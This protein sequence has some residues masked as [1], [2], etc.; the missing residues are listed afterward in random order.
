MEAANIF[1]NTQ[2]RSR[3][4]FVARAVRET[5][6]AADVGRDAAVVGGRFRVLQQV[7]R[8]VVPLCVEVQLAVV[9]VVQVQLGLD[10]ELECPSCSC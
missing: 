7:E 6:D 9:F 4:E 8:V 3:L 5:D 1:S 2:G 10:V